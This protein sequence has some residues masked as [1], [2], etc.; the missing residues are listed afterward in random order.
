MSTRTKTKP[1]YQT[2]TA[3]LNTD[4][5]PNIIAWRGDRFDVIPLSDGKGG[6]IARV[7]PADPLH[8]AAPDLLAALRNA[9]NV[10]AALATGQLQGIEKDSPA[11]IMAREAIA[12]AT[13]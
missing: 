1:I 10:L 12:K 2:V 5:S 8:L 9:A 4:G 3:N 6:T 11:L 13:N 7:V